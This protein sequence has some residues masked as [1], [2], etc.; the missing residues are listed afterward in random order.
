MP[1]TYVTEPGDT[2]WALAERYYG[3]GNLWT[4]IYEANRPLLGDNPNSLFAGKTL[5]I[6]D[7]FPGNR[8]PSGVRTYV[9]TDTDTLWDIA[10]R[11]YGNGDGWPAIY[12]ANKTA[13]GNDPNVLRGGLTLIIP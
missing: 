4:A 11:F 5:I 7:V 9:T 3:D 12:E 10:Q 8:P 6:P 13:I 2:L 1:Q